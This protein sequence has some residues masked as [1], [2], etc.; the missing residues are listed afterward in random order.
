MFAEGCGF[1]RLHRLIR[2]AAVKYLRMKEK[3]TREASASAI[4]LQSLQIPVTSRT[5]LYDRCSTHDLHDFT[6]THVDT[7]LSLPFIPFSTEPAHTRPLTLFVS[8]VLIGR[9]RNGSHHQGISTGAASGAKLSR[10]GVCC[11]GSTATPPA[12]AA[13]YA[14]SGLVPGVGMLDA[15]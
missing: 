14:C 2:K 11:G 13:G 4:A 10:L 8:R 12:P 5:G 3:W 9:P 7:L 15:H 1:R 6:H